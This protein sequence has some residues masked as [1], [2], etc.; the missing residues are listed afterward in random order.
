[1]S[2]EKPSDES[3]VRYDRQGGRPQA[4]HALDD[5]RERIGHILGERITYAA[6]VDAATR[7]AARRAGQGPGAAQFHRRAG[8]GT[9]GETRGLCEPTRPDAAARDE[10]RP[11]RFERTTPGLGNRCSILLSYGRPLAVRTAI[12]NLDQHRSAVPGGPRKPAGAIRGPANP[13]R[14]R[15]YQTPTKPATAFRA[16]RKPPAGEAHLRSAPKQ[17]GKLLPAKHLC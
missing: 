16:L 4:S 11:V 12:P 7:H 13:Q 6:A 10:T 9:A 3:R 2:A 1:M 8:Y 17:Y 15:F 14:R 5:P